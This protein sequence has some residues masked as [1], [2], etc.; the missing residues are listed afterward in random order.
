MWV[1]RVGGSIGKGVKYATLVGEI[2]LMGQM[3]RRF[4]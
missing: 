4:G 3:F 2:H 1:R